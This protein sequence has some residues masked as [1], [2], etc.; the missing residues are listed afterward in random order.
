MAELKNVITVGLGGTVE[1][2]KLTENKR[3][4][5]W[6]TA[7]TH[8]GEGE[9]TTLVSQITTMRGNIQYSIKYSIKITHRI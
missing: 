3:Y 6:L 1:I 2:R 7:H 9:A 4:E 8:A 5:F